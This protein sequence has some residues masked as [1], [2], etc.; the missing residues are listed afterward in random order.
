M[1]CSDPC[2]WTE[3][4]VLHTN[5]TY[6]TIKIESVF[7]FSYIFLPSSAKG[8]PGEKGLKGAPGRPG[9]VGPPGEIGKEYFHFLIQE[10]LAMHL[11]FHIS[12]NVFNTTK[13]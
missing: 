13:S 10:K 9:R 2:P 8:E 12:H 3:R 5:H 1:H 6:K 4:H 11:N 7:R